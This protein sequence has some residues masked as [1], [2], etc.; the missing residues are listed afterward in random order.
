MLLIPAIDLKDGQ[1]VR[2]RQGA[3]DDATIFSDDPVKV[4]AH[5]RDQ[6]ARRL[7]LVDLNGAF[8]GKPKNL[9]VIRDILGEVGE[10]MPVQLG[11]GIRDLDTIEAYLDMGLSYVI[12]GTAAVKTPGFLHDACDAFPGQ[13]IVGL[14]A[15]DG[16]VAI[17]GWAKITNHNVVDL[18]KRFEDYG[19]NSVIYT[20]IGRDGMMTGV[21][22]E[23]TVKLA[24]A[25][26]IP[27]IASGGLTNLDDI[28]ALCEVEAEGI[29]GAI[30][31]RAIY[32]G[33]IDFAAAQTLADEL[34]G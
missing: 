22:I 26:T 3:M 8:A 24:Q 33:S 16:M 5:W 30:T 15:K 17:D 12:I 29:E 27:V 19:V 9:S 14:D 6:G 21:N 20:D 13:V 4:A 2:L 28:R 18:A 1:C 34:A 25:L 7:H 11:G 23:A 10:D 32:E 31:G